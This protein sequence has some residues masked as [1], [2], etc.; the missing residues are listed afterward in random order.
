MTASN[1]KIGFWC[2]GLAGGM[3]G[4]AFASVPLYDLFCKVTGYGGTP[5]VA[6]AALHQPIARQ[7]KIRFDAN[8]SPELGWTFAPEKNQIEIP[9][10]ETTTVSYKVANPTARDS[11]GMATF[12]VEPEQAGAYF[13][14]VQCFCYTEHQLKAGKADEAVVVFYIDPAIDND[15]DLK[16]LNTIT[17]SYTYFP[18]K[19]PAQTSK[20]VTQAPSPTLTR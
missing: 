17:L 20:T 12:N 8:V 7:M 19:K 6:Q 10:G 2:A 13:N 14:K 16:Y 3:L 18:S 11:V 9:V 1:N 4:L 5:Q 15:P